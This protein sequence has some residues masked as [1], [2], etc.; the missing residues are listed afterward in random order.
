MSTHT[1]TPAGHDATDTHD[2]PTDTAGPHGLNR[3]WCGAFNAGDLAA[4]M[5]TYEP[6]AVIVPGPGAEPLH[7]HAAIEAALSW[8]LGLGGT[9]RFEPRYWLEQGDLVLS[10]IAFV[11]DGGT[12]ADGRPVDLRGV[13]AEVLRRQPDGSWKYVIDHPFGASS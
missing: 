9:L 7:G 11:M 6:D 1:L 13:T 8:F 5:S 12:D 10:S 4:L 3:F 2:V